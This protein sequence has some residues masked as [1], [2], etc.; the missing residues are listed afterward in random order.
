MPF[1]WIFLYFQTRNDNLFHFRA[2]AWHCCC[3]QAVCGC[4][5]PAQV[6][7]GDP[8]ED[9]GAQY[10]SGPKPGWGA[11]AVQQGAEPVW[12]GDGQHNVHTGFLWR[13]DFWYIDV[14]FNL[15]SNMHNCSV[16]TC[17][18][19]RLSVYLRHLFNHQ[20]QARLDGAFCSYTE[21]DKQDYLKKADEAGVCNIEMESSVFAAMCKLSGLR[22][23][24]I[25]YQHY[26]IA[27]KIVCVSKQML[28]F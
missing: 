7:T 24:K 25:Q 3:H 17:T 19:C 22:G 16:V 6:W 13:Y 21:K 23:T 18:F 11:V 2:W 14:V 10:W 27:D 20:G 1:N 12:D 15:F 5:L 4:R 28:S 9:G 8:G 26:I